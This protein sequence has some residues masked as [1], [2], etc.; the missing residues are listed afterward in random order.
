MERYCSGSQA[1]PLSGRRLD[2]KAFPEGRDITSL[3]VVGMLND[4][5]GCC[6]FSRTGPRLEERKV[7]LQVARLYPFLNSLNDR[8]KT[9]APAEN[10]GG[11]GYSV[12]LLSRRSWAAGNA[13]AVIGVSVGISN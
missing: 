7:R 13:A 10:G 8:M 9:D 2:L 12:H 11:L 5:G 4:Y 6:T 1:P 3:T